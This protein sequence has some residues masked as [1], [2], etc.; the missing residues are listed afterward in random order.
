MPRLARHVD[1]HASD[2]LSP[3]GG[4]AIEAHVIF[5]RTGAYRVIIIRRSKPDEYTGSPIDPAGISHEARRY[6]DVAAGE[7]TVERKRQAIFIWVGGYL[8]QSSSSV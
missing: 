2:R 4:D 3:S 6:V 8:R 7:R 1:V 5:E